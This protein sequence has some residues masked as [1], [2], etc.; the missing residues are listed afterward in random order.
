MPPRLFL[1][2]KLKGKPAP[3]V[4]FMKKRAY[5]MKEWAHIP[6]VGEKVSRESKLYNSAVDAYRKSRK[7]NLTVW[8]WGYK[9]TLK[10]KG[11]NFEVIDLYYQ[12]PGSTFNTG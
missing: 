1:S 3:L 12:T 4:K 10:R 6:E 9:F 8:E 5:A 2:R 7:D 11:K